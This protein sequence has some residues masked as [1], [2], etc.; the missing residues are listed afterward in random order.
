MITRDPSHA[1]YDTKSIITA[2]IIEVKH[3]RAFLGETFRQENHY[4]L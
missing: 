2:G 4:W 1:G 3:Q